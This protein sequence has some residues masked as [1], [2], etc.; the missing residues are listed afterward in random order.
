M[1]ITEI[2]VGNSRL[3]QRMKRCVFTGILLALL[4]VTAAS[5]SCTKAATTTTKTAAKTTAAV[6]TTKPVIT[7]PTKTTTTTTPVLTQTNFTL[8]ITAPQTYAEYTQPIYLSATDT[9]HF[10]WTVS[11]VGEHIRMG[12]NTP[13]GQFV[14]VKTA[15]GFTAMTAD[16]PCDQLNRSGSVVFKP[17]DQKWVDGYYVFHPYISDKDPTVNVKI[18]YWI[19]R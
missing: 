6:P 18:L 3:P 2:K 9:I 13:D 17:A 16:K 14:G 12:I 7:T 1:S 11:G 19:E 4:C 15:G 5:I 10:V 8:L